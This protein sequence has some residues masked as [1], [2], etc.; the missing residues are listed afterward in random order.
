MEATILTSPDMMDHLYWLIGCNLDR[1]GGE[2]IVVEEG[3]RS[4]KEIME[5]GFGDYQGILLRWLNNFG[6]ENISASQKLEIVKE[7]LD[8]QFKG[9]TFR[10]FVE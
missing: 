2:G 7:I 4:V 6:P 10:Y 5:L 8:R 3:E 1:L 9:Q